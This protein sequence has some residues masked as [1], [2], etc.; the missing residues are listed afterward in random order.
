MDKP[1]N[2]EWLE[3]AHLGLQYMKSHGY[4]LICTE[5]NAIHWGKHGMERKEYWQTDTHKE[6]H[7]EL[8]KMIDQYCEMGPVTIARLLLI[9]GGYSRNIT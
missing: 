9:Q 4:T 5:W 8:L 1:W 2:K 6:Y 3:K 7:L